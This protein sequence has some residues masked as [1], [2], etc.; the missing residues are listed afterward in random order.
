[1]IEFLHVTTRKQK[2]PLADASK[3]VQAWLSNFALMTT[4]PT[5]VE[6]TLS[7]LKSHR[8]EI[9]D[10]QMLAICASYG[11]DV[12]LSEDMTDGAL[13]GRVRV[14][15]PFNPKNASAIAEILLP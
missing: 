2:Q 15:N 6:D 11:C 3:I 13:Y 1:V 14:L 10:A 9:W 5:I 7:I 12:L 4:P 8:L